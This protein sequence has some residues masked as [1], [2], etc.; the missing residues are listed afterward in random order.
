VRADPDHGQSCACDGC[1]GLVDARTRQSPASLLRTALTELGLSQS[2]AARI[3]GI[4]ER[5]MRRYCADQLD[6]PPVVFMALRDMKAKAS[7]GKD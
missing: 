1:L 3:L 6:V 2:G 5:T 4:S 7:I